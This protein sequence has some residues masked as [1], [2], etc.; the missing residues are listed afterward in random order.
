MSP[1]L[2]ISGLGTPLLALAICLALLPSL[3]CLTSELS[4]ILCGIVGRP[5]NRGGWLRKSLAG[6]PDLSGRC[7]QSRVWH[8]AVILG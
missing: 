8:A 3:F 7:S 1:G 2:K 6:D 5:G 4:I